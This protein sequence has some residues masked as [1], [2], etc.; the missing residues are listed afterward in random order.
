VPAGFTPPAKKRGIGVY[1]PDQYESPVLPGVIVDLGRFADYESVLGNSAPPAATVSQALSTG[2][3]WRKARLSAEAWEAYVKA[4]EASAWKAATPLLEEVKPLFLYA[5][6]KNAALAT[7]YPSLAAYC[8]AAKEASV[9]AV[10]TRK[11]NAKTKAAASAAAATA[12]AVA[13][14]S[15]S[16]AAA[17]KAEAAAVV[18]PSNGV[19]VN[20]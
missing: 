2:L 16:A 8:N 15:A 9:H 7:K 18:V 1:F 10:T 12:A 3:G 4:G 13:A 19:T 17:A 11:K 14:A 5:V 20:A 6:S